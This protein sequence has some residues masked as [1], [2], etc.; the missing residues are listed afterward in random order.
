[1]PHIDHTAIW[2]ADLEAARDFYL[3]WFGG[4]ANGQYHNPRTGLRTYIITF[5]DGAHVSDGRGARLELMSRPDVDARSDVERL[6]W[7]HISFALPDRAGVDDL[8]AR[9]RAAGVPVI[10]GPRQTGDGYYEAV[11]LDP[12]GNRVEIVAGDYSDEVAER[13]G[14]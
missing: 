8:A 5:D 11:L 14:F 13:P 10:D 2:V 12:E 9:A 4:R 6:G 3:Y 1:M 7:A